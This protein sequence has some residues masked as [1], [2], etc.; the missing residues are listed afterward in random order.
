MSKNIH[1]FGLG[2]G[3]YLISPDGLLIK[4]PGSTLDKE[5]NN[6]LDVNKYIE[7]G[8]K[9]KFP[10]THLLFHISR[11][12]KTILIIAGRQFNEHQQKT[13]MSFCMNKGENFPMAIHFCEDNIRESLENFIKPYN[14]IANA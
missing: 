8:G 5:E 1:Y 12:R 6:D 14:V 11:L 4:I 10:D 3:L 2:G 9:Y 7:G 13:L